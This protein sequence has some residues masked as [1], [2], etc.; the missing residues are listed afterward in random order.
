[1]S[2]DIACKSCG[3]L[4]SPSTGTCPYCK[5]VIAPSK[6]LE[7]ELPHVKHLKEYY[8]KGKVAEALY[9]GKKIW[10][11]NDKAKKSVTFISIF[12][13]VLFECEA[14]PAL[15]MS[16]I[17]QNQ[18]LDKPSPEVSLIKDIIVAKSQLEKGKND[19]GEVMLRKILAAHPKDPYANF[20]LGAHLFFVEEDLRNSII[21]LE[22]SVKAYP[23]FLRAWGCLG[24]IY[25]KIGNE[26]LAARSFKQ[27]IK[28]ESD[29]KMKAF[30]KSMI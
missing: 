26:A 12:T 24:S 9:V 25:K 1:M 4:S 14:Y 13:R 21:H 8:G 17:A 27:A 28:L 2:F 20:V 15:L 6:K 19:P 18:F 7:K 22:K 23:N 5:S 16:V 29:P 10:D 30:F 11:E 3:A